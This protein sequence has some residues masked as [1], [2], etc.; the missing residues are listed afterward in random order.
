MCLLCIEISKNRMSNKEI[1]RAGMEAIPN[2]H[3]ETLFALMKEKLSIEEF[4][5]FLINYAL[6]R[7]DENN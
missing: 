1:V 5:E 7:N 4:E 3:I 2:N 6:R